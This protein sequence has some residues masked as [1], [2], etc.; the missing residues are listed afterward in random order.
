LMRVRTEAAAERDGVTRELAALGQDK[1]RM[2]L[3]LDQRQK[4]Q[5]DVE[6][7]LET[8][9][10]RAGQ[11]SRQADNLKDLS[12]KLEQ[13]LDSAS[14]AAR[15]AAGAAEEARPS[16]D[17]RLTALHDPG[18][19]GPA[20]A[21]ASAK[22]MLPLPVNGIKTRDFGWADGNGGTERGI[23]ITTRTGA[24]VTSPCDGWVVY[25]AP[26][27]SY[28]QLLILNAGGGYHVLLAGMGRISV[29]LGQFVLTG[30]PV[31][32][33]GNGPSVASALTAGTAGASQPALYIEFRK[34]GSPV[35]PNPWWVSTDSQ[36]V[37]G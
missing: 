4:H 21:F 26:Y 1:Y 37:R 28:G 13:G 30:E 6:K 34:D 12:A 7:A 17:A 25:A 36:K 32:V 10:A 3:L 20:V 5:T 22:G 33:M 11:L 19:L 35:D 27:R 31:G 29:D 15:A 16:G 24:Q 14:R 2:S 9:R 8:E 18:R 23:S